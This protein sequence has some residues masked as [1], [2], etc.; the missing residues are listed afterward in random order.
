MAVGRALASRL[1]LFLTA[2][3]PPLSGWR[4]SLPLPPPTSPTIVRHICFLLTPG[5]REKKSKNRNMELPPGLGPTS[6]NGPHGAEPGPELGGGLGAGA[7]VLLGLGQA[8]PGREAPR[9][10]QGRRR[11]GP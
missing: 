11:A 8:S 9:G 5:K 7:T 2:L 10:A 4:S 6:Q 1:P 3:P